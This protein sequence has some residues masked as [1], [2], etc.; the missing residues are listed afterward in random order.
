MISFDREKSGRYV[1]TTSRTEN[2]KRN[3]FWSF[4]DY[5]I[6][7]IFQFVSRTIIVQV[8]GKEYLGISSLYTS[9][10]QVLSMTELGFSS[11]IIFN[12]YKPIANNDHETVC[13]LL[14]FYRK[15]YRAVSI[16]ILVIGLAIS[17]FLRSLINGDVPADLNMYILYYLY[18]ANTVV[19]YCLFAYKASLLNALQRMDLTKIAYSI[20]NAA[21]CIFQVIVLLLFHNYY[22]FVVG[23]ILGTAAKNILAAYVSQKKYPQYICKGKITDKTKSDI[24]QRVK[25]LLIGRISGVTY[26]TFDS[27]ILSAMIGLVPVAIYGNYMTIYNSVANIIILIRYAMQAS[28][29]NSI[30]SESVEKN[31][32]DIFRWQFI[33]SMIAIWCAICLI[34]LYQPFMTIWMG[35]EMLLSTAD[36]VILGI[37]FAVST[38]QHAFYLYLSGYGLWWQ[39][40]WPYILSTVTNLVLNIILCK[41]WG[42]TGIIFATLVAQLIFGMIW[43]STIVFRE[44]FKQSV[45][46][47]FKKQFIYFLTGG[48]LCAAVFFA[49]SLITVQGTFGL[50]CKVLIC[51]IVPPICLLC[52]FRKTDEF[53]ESKRLISAVFKR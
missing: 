19:S 22:L 20:V 10:L 27:I 23:T 15:V 39:L 30:A 41:L 11:A 29:G 45:L 21:Q 7:I 52:I 12:L 42:I 24:W 40:R 50:V 43:Q 17:P 36:T 35:E 28:V 37:L 18:L 13:A 33:F 1:L 34:C 53:A 16:F 14:S 9:I 26:T 2:T 8:L 38:V 25:G 51:A 5:A 3:L 47:Y 31:Y 6:S 46:T 48:I 4:A 49:C 32:K 44:Y